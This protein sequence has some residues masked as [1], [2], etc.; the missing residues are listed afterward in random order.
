MVNNPI[1]FSST[2]SEN[3]LVGAPPKIGLR[4]I[5]A[6]LPMTF[7]HFGYQRIGL[8]VETAIEQLRGI[9]EELV[10]LHA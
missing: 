9:D 8:T 5:M 2:S 6:K 7:E 10:D 1:Y 3:R 4:P